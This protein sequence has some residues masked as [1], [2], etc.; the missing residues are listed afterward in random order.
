M[1]VVSRRVKSTEGRW[2]DR[3]AERQRA[4]I[5]AL[6]EL[7]EESEP[8]AEISFQDIADR[9]GISRTVLYRHFSDRMDLDNQAREH[10]VEMYLDAVMPVLDPAETVRETVSIAVNNYVNLV[11]E[12]P[13]LYQWMEL[14]S[15]EGFTGSTAVI[16]AKDAIARQI[17]SFITPIA[18]LL[19]QTDPGLDVAV[20]A[21]VSM[22][23][24]AVTRWLRDTPEGWDAA[25][26]AR[27]LTDSFLI[28]LEGH[29]RLRG[30]TIDVDVPID[31][32]VASA[33][34]RPA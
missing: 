17:S 15:H 3:N 18:A 10:V 24:G 4:V 8:R 28:L 29:A 6:I 27:M 1:G 22:I 32:L 13:R 31:D 30:V 16:S 34:N 2:A 21:M 25:G 20:F 26:V 19:G 23:D 12:H 7:V 11:A 14:A 9:A 5:E 33:L